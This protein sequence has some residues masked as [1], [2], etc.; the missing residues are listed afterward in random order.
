MLFLLQDFAQRF[1]E[2]A[3]LV[4]GHGGDNGLGDVL[5]LG[6]SL[7]PTKSLFGRCRNARSM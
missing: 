3:G 6:E 4:L 1:D 7:T 2:S 5:G